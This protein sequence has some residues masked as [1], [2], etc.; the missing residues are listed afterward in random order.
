M[1][2]RPSRAL[3]FKRRVLALE[4]KGSRLAIAE[5]SE[6]ER[7][8]TR[9]RNDPNVNARNYLFIW[10]RDDAKRGIVTLYGWSLTERRLDS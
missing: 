7:Q 3:R 9:D 8:Y 4:V 6:T 5:R 2:A 1:M 10:T